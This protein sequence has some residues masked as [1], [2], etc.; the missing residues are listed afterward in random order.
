M[1]H[2]PWVTRSQSVEKLTNLD[3][4]HQSWWIATVFPFLH[5]CNQKLHQLLTFNL[6]RDSQ[7]LVWMKLFSRYLIIHNDK[8][9]TASVSVDLQNCF[10]HIDDCIF[11][12]MYFKSMLSPSCEAQTIVQL[13]HVSGFVL[14]FRDKSI[15]LESHEFRQPISNK[16]NNLVFLIIFVLKNSSWSFLGGSIIPTTIPPFHPSPLRSMSNIQVNAPGWLMLICLWKWNMIG[17]AA[18]MVENKSPESSYQVMAIQRPS[19]LFYQPTKWKTTNLLPKA[20]MTC[21]EP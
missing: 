11:Y 1:I 14:D 12:G 3:P 5:F 8:Q 2:S 6:L 9:N 17:M 10:D 21:D 4:S 18:N 19:N 20:F 16:R 15:S 13:L 7:H